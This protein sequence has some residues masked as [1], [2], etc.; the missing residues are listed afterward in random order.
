MKKIEG[1]RKFIV[2]SGSIILSF[3]ALM[4]GNLPPQTFEYIVV[5]CTG[6]FGVTNAIEGYMHSRNGGRQEKGSGGFHGPPEE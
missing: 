6:I 5:Y 4:M 1:K 2:A 3:I